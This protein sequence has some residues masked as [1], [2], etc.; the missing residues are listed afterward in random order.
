MNGI[1]IA[2]TR[3]SGSKDRATKLELKSVEIDAKIDPAIFV[4]P[5]KP[6]E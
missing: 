3:Q 6:P 1:K 5:A 4:K 2:H